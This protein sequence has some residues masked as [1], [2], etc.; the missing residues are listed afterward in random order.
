[1][2]VFFFFKWGKGW[3]LV[4]C[5]IW[6]F[7]LKSTLKSGNNVERTRSGHAQKHFASRFIRDWCRVHA[8]QF[9]VPPTYLALA[10]L[11]LYIFP[12]HSSSL[13]VFTLKPT[14]TLFG[15]SVKKCIINQVEQ[16]LSQ[17]SYN[18][19]NCRKEAWKIVRLRQYSNSCLL[20]TLLW[21]FFTWFS[22][23]SSF[24]I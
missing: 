10:S 14:C 13:L 6:I 5:D 15:V 23:R 4:G 21:R 7:S 1:M 2:L 19:G 12:S 20:Y 24:L 11:N 22:N 17:L 8:Q 3:G 18:F 9:V 16:C